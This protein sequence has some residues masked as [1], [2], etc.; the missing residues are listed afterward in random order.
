VIAVAATLNNPDRKGPGWRATS[1][2][3]AGTTLQSGFPQG[4]TKRKWP[5]IRIS[6]AVPKTRI[7]PVFL[8]R[9]LGF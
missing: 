5:R 7:R 3:L 6:Q 9:T 1:M 2:R 8:G 4:L